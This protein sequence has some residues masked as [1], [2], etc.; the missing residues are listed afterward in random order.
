MSKLPVSYKIIALSN[1]LLMEV[2]I[3]TNRQGFTPIF[4]VMSVYTSITKSGCRPLSLVNYKG[5]VICTWNK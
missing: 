4:N 5:D 3:V 1:G 2:P